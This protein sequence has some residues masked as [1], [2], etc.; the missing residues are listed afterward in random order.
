MC[1]YSESGVE[2]YSTEAAVL[3]GCIGTDLN[4][5]SPFSLVTQR[6]IRLH[7]DIYMLAKGEE[8]PILVLQ[9]GVRKS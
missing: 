2:Q 5:T 4:N 7:L 9:L 6:V 8:F 3:E 1:I